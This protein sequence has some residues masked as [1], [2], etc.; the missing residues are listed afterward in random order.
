MARKKRNPIRIKKSKQGTLRAQTSKT[1]SG[2]IS[3]KE[4]ARKKKSKDPA[5]RKKA[6]FAE[7]AR[8]WGKKKG[9]K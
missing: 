9:G 3:K 5:V 6:V 2:K 7:N 4:L 1:K 8:K